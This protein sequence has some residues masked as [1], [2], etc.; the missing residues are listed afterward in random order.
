MKNVEIEHKTDYDL[1]PYNTLRISSIAKDVYF[2]STEE[3]FVLLLANLDSPL[4]IGGGSNILLSSKGIDVPVIVTKRLNKIKIEPPA[5]EISA[6]AL[7]PKLADMALE[8]KLHGF[9]FLTSLPATLGGA[10]CMNA[11]AIGQN[12]SDYF[13]SAKVYD[14][15][16]DCVRVFSK[17]DMNFSYR[18][19]ILKNQ[20]RYF[21]LSAKFK[22]EEADSYESIQNLMS[23]NIEKRKN[24]QPT[25]KDPNIGCVFRNPVNENGEKVSAGKLLD[26]CNLKSCPFGGAM[27]YHKHANFIINFNNATSLDY[28]NL[29]LEMQKRV[30][31]K[32][33]IALQPEILYFGS[34][35]NEV[36]IWKQL[37]KKI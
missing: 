35:K 26:E 29:M 14:S 32:F 21:L 17:E 31:E 33:K 2:P 37:T 13:I 3:E 16:D 36:W 28:L 19:S 10:V 30:F 9:E 25:L 4:V 12:I 24:S 5:F 11:G 15:N 34:D 8:L 1:K 20:D 27:V 18:N 23:E 6:G 22:L 7:A